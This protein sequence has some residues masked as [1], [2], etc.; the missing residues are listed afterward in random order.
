MSTPKRFYWMKLKESFMTSDT[1][2]YFMGQPDG[3]NYVVIYQLLCLKTINTGGRLSRQIGEVIIP[4]DIPT[5]PS[6]AGRSL[7]AFHNQVISD[8]GYD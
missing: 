4:Y 6:P 5:F 7:S 3:A 8:P 1:V 2:D